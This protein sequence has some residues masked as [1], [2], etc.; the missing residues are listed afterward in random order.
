MSQIE[1]GREIY[2]S[3]IFKFILRLTL[4]HFHFHTTNR[5][6]DSVQ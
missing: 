4:A 6:A 1:I 5:V 3:Q 2:Y